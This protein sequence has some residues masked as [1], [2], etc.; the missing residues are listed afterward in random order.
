MGMTQSATIQ[1]DAVPLPRSQLSP[2]ALLSW[3]SVL[4]SLPA[5]PF[6][7]YSPGAFA[8]ARNYMYATH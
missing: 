3:F 2:L 4:P 6:V 5:D 1:T 8:F 7:R